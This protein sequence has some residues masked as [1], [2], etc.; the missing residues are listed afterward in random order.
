MNQTPASTK[1]NPF[2][3]LQIKEF[4]LFLS[5]RFFLILAIQMQSIIVG[6]QIYHHTKD[7]LALGMIGLA[8][9]IP[10]IIVS[11]FSGHVADNFNRKYIL[12][13]FSFLLIISTSALFYFSLP[14]SSIITNYGV[15][16]IYLVIA[17]IG[18]I[19]GFISA[20][21]PSFM[22][23]IVSRDLYTNATTWNSTTWHIASVIGPAVAG[24]ICAISY[25]TA[26]AINI[27]LIA[28][29]LIPLILITSKPLPIKELNLSVVEL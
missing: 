8:E 28:I 13:I 7:V 22:A 15:T 17:S 19:R 16:P 14:S 29:S 23:Q 4:V 2:A 25:S 9:A 1:N 18:I 12:L 10:F 3:A 5:S 11:L 20:S 21:S 27:I 6:L 24:F 26:Y